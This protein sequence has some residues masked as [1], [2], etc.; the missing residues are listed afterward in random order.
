MTGARL[1][2]MLAAL[3][4]L[5]PAPVHADGNVEHGRT[6]AQ[7]HCSRCHVVGTYNP[8]G[9]IGSTPSLQLLVNAFDD[10]EARFETFFVRRPHPAFV[11]VKG[12]PRHTELP[13][14]AAPVTIEIEEVQDLLA[15][16]ATLKSK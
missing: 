11:T 14:N 16:V 9:G 12:Y 2:L 3:F 7:L 8:S 4:A 15:F 10:W 13:P 1:T 5:V 6:L